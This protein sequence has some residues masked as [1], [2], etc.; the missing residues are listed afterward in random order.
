MPSLEISVSKAWLARA[1]GV[2]FDRAYYL[3][4][5]HR[6]EVDARCHEHVRRELAGLDACFTESNLGRRAHMDDAQV[7]VGGIQ[8]NLIQGM[9]LGAELVAHPAMDADITPA[10][11]KGRD[12]SELPSPE[13]QLEHELVRRLDR[14]I[15]EVRARGGLVPIPPFF[16]DASGRAAVH[17]TL[18]TAQKL[19]GEDVLVDLIANPDRAR[20]A[21]EWVAESNVALVRHFAERGGVRIADVHVGECASCTVGPAPWEELVAPTLERMGEALGPLRLHSCGPSDHLLEVFR[22]IR[23][24]GSLDL[25]GETSLGRVRALFGPGFPVSI[26]PPVACLAAAT[27]ESLREWAGRA[28]EENEGGDLVILLHLEPDYALEMPRALREAV[29]AA[30]G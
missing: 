9:L 12:P 16:W 21:M 3:D 23:T 22:G 27:P 18:T 15:D 13:E 26:A 24:L 28:L 2:V 1:I 4:P 14:Q 30:G 25:G 8:P 29:E 17:G 6:R 5:F 11:A 20:R 7:L 19:F 10:C